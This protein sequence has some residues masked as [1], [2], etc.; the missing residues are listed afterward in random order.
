MGRPREWHQGV[1]A[2]DEMVAAGVLG[3]RSAPAKLKSA[4][5]LVISLKRDSGLHRGHRKRRITLPAR[6]ADTGTASAYRV[7][8]AT[9]RRMGATDGE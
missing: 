8:P 1:I 2:A 7:S 5:L 6:V 4:D 3:P 9:L